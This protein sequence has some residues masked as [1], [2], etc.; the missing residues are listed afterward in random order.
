MKSLAEAPPAAKPGA[1]DTAARKPCLMLLKMVLL[2]QAL[3]RL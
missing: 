1:D 2:D 3:G